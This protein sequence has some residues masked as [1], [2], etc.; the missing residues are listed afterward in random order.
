MYSTA[1]N[2]QKRQPKHNPQQAAQNQPAGAQ[3]KNHQLFKHQT[4]KFNNKFN[5]NFGKS[6]R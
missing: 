4:W 5:T 6:T 3:K 1:C 2:R